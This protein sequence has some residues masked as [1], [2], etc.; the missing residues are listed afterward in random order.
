[1]YSAS[2]SWVPGAAALA[3]GRCHAQV[4]RAPSSPLAETSGLAVGISLSPS[5]QP[6]LHPS[7]LRPR[8]RS[9]RALGSGP[10]AVPSL[11]DSPFPQRRV[12][13]G[14]PCCCRLW[15]LLSSGRAVCHR[16]RGAAPLPAHLPR[17]FGSSA[18]LAC[19]TVLQWARGC[20]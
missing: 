2:G 5:L 13:G 12:L 1:M 6:C 16:T 17:V 8:V 7:A 9:R 11:C 10:H 18:R 15:N 20:A 4:P 19:Q 14:R 3:A